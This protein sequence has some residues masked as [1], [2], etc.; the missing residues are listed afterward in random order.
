MSASFWKKKI[1]DV[2]G[3]FSLN[4]QLYVYVIEE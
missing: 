4:T 2:T 1:G 3:M